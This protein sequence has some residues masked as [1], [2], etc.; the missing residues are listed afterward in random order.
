MAEAIVQ[1]ADST[2]GLNRIAAAR[3]ALAEVLR[4]A[5]LYGE[6]DHTIG[7]AVHLY[8]RKGNSVGASQARDRLELEVPA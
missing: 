4:F 3:L 1:L 8:E 6:A 7:E 2:D 5:D